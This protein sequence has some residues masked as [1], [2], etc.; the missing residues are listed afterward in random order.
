M[1][2]HS[3]P[4]TWTT[5]AAQR[6]AHRRKGADQSVRKTSKRGRHAPVIWNLKKVEKSSQ[7][8][9]KSAQKVNFFENNFQKISNSRCQSG[10]RGLAK[11]MTFFR[12]KIF[13]GKFLIPGVSREKVRKKVCEKGQFWQKTGK[14]CAKS[15]FSFGGVF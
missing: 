9:K 11:K 15:G 4:G 3:P 5:K 1:T 8:V 14:K 2:A 10:K 13:P 12:K 7:K 6:G